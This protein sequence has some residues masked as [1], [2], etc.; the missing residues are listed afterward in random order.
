M[1]IVVCIA[2]IVY[3]VGAY[4]WILEVCFQQRTLK[5][6]F[7]EDEFLVSSRDPIIHFLFP[8]TKESI[9][10]DNQ[11]V[12]KFSILCIYPYNRNTLLGPVLSSF[13]GF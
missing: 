1:D 5:T 9:Y 11:Y 2:C 4:G 6:A 3:C 7:A 8:C 12:S 13:S 10:K